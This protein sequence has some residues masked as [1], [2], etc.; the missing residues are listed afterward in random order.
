MKTKPSR[1]LRQIN[2]QMHSPLRVVTHR[3]SSFSKLF[4]PRLTLPACSTLELEVNFQPPSLP[5]SHP[6]LLPLS[7]HKNKQTTHT[8]GHR[9]SLLTHLVVAKRR[10][11]AAN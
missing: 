8:D 11:P 5:P 3:N 6:F 7:P 9:L 2:P 10:E 4:P 1:L